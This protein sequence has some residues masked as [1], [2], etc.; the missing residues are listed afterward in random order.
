[1]KKSF[2]LRQHIEVRLTR[3]KVKEFA[4]LASTGEVDMKELFHLCFDKDT[5]VA[6]RAS[7]ILEHI[8][9]A[10]PDLFIP[11]F[12]A[13]VSRLSGQ[14]NRSC[15]RHFSKILM[16]VTS[17]DVIHPY[18]DVLM[19]DC[20]NRDEIVEVAFRWLIDPKTPV[21]VQA[22]CMD[23]L[24]NMR[25]EYPWVRE[26][27]PLQINF[28]MLNGSAAIQSRGRKILKRMKL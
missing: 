10:F 15:Q 20:K 13:F 17:Q 2:E 14:S 23:I 24:F 22:N 5:T 7:W 16:H 1:M 12:F 26:E 21:A 18:D 3:N 25:Y 28:C 6:F 9:I 11:L 27:L 8:A 19:A 4:S